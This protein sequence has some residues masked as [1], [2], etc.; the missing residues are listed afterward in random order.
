MIRRVPFLS[1]TH[2]G[3][4]LIPS[5]RVAVV[6]AVRLSDGMSVGI[7]CQKRTWGNEPW[8]YKQ[9]LGESNDA[10]AEALWNLARGELAGI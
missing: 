4:L 5:D 9:V 10:D 8:S 6:R 2:A 7:N 3:V 1:Q